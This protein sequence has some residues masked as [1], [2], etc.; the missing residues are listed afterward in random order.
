MVLLHVLS[1]RKVCDIALSIGVNMALI[2]M[3]QQVLWCAKKVIV[4][5]MDTENKN[6]RVSSKKQAVVQALTVTL[7]PTSTKDNSNDCK[8]PL[9]STRALSKMLGFSNGGGG[10]RHILKAS[11]KREE[12]PESNAEEWCMIDDDNIC[13][14]YSDTLLDDLEA[15]MND[16]DMVC[17]NPNKGE[18]ILKRDQQGKIVRDPITKKPFNVPK[19]LMTCNPRELH[20]HMI[21]KVLISKSQI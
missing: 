10:W 11:K 4:R 7:L 5:A 8:K 18:T 12:I 17:F 15:W 2:Q 20:N 13:T 6:F 21:S 19:L 3:C 9:I 14:K 1:D 16:N